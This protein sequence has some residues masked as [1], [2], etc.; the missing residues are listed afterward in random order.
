MAKLEA[1]LEVGAVG[2]SVGD[3]VGALVGLKE[4]TD[5]GSL[6]GLS[7]GLRGRTEGA[8]AWSKSRR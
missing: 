8:K 6:E 5:V 1:Y 4:G 2:L 3:G 7:V